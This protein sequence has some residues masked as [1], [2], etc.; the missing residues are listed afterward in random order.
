MDAS[1][2]ATLAP[3]GICPHPEARSAGYEGDKGDPECRRVDRPSSH[4]SQHAD[5]PTASQ[6]TSSAR[7]QHQDW[8]DDNDAAISNPLDEKNRLHNAY[9]D[10]SSDKNKAAFYRSRR[11]VEQR[12][13]EVQ[14]AWTARKAAEIQ[15][16]VDRNEWKN[17]FSAIKAV[18]GP[19][20]KGTAHLL[21]AYSSTL[22]TQ[23]TQILQ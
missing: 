11:L 16:Y 14:G 15:G 7:R 22:H 9:V 10:H 21:S 23:K 3:A 5:P 4:H 19:P 17:F 12:L 6:E 18:Y 13:Q 2:V 20:T 1:T 8:F